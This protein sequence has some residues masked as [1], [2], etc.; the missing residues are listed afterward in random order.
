[1]P[2]NLFSTFKKCSDVFF[3]LKFIEMNRLMLKHYQQCV[4][5]VNSNN[6]H[7]LQEPPFT[8]NDTLQFVLLV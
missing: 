3:A 4:E 2:H 5:I 1:M 8:H 7:L 6:G